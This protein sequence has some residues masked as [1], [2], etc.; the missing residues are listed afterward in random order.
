MQRAVE[1]GRGEASLQAS[2][3]TISRLGQAASH[4]TVAGEPGMGD[5]VDAGIR[6]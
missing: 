1:V 2:P 3:V 4:H 6:K 5:D